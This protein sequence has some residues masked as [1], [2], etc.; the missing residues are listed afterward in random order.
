MTVVVTGATGFVGSAVVRSLLK[1]GETVRVMARAGSDRRNL[2]GLDIEV[3]EADLLAPQS[4]AALV[5]DAGGLY[6][7]AAD[8][9]LWSRRPDEIYQANLEGTRNLIRAAAD[10]GV[11][12]IV[13]T[14]S[15]ATLGINRD[16]TPADE[17]TPSSL[18]DMIGHYKRSKY[19]AEEAVKELITESGLP[20]VIVNPSTP[21]GPRDVKPTPTGRMIVEAA[22]GR[23][24]AFV[25]T[26][27]NVVHVDDVAEGHLLAYDVG[28]V[29]E[30]YI[31]GG[32]NMTLAEILEGIARLTGGRA[33]RVKLPH[34]LVM[35]IA[36]ASEAWSRLR[37]NGTPFV[38]HEGVR[39]ARKRMFFSSAKAIS[40]LGY[41]FRPWEEAL[42]DSIDWFKRGGYLQ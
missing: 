8:Y 26:G 20:I 16:G 22:A 3:V 27:L 33:P 18:E 23:M 15:V 36:A 5:A 42:S 25:D 34:S 31:L 30:R 28:K 32:T 7:L 38:T 13:Y 29:G 10:A 11:K 4:L 40:D 21:I 37:P 12:R 24:P 14:S 6:H 2:E 19:L 1:R 17:E 9:R 35:P 39:M 41:R